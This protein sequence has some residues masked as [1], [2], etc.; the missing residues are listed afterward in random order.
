MSN[1]PRTCHCGRAEDGD[2][3][4]LPYGGRL[5]HHANEPCVSRAT[6]SKGESNE[7][8]SREL[9]GCSMHGVWRAECPACARTNRPCVHERERDSL[10]AAL[11]KAQE[12][13]AH[14]TESAGDDSCADYIQRAEAA[15][16]K[17]AKATAALTEL[18]AYMQRQLGTNG[19]FALQKDR[20]TF[21]HVLDVLA[22][23][24]EVKGPSKLDANSDGEVGS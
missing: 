20:E 10:R 24:R 17:L 23:I 14:L 9:L 21:N 5:Y 2:V 12:Q 15:E 19:D 7:C 8:E 11:A 22:A 18:F 1:T 6:P 13:L 4:G 16:A 3:E